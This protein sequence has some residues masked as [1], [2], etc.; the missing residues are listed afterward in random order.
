VRR[1]HVADLFLP[2]YLGLIAIWPSDWSG[3]RFLLPVLPVILFLAGEGTLRLLRMMAPRQAFV[4]GAAIVALFMAIEA[5]GLRAAAKDS[6]QCIAAYEAG[7]QYPCIGDFWREYFML[8]EMLPVFVPDSSV[9]IT[10]NPRMT[11][12]LGGVQSMIWPFSD[13]PNAFFAAADSVAARYLIYDGATLST[14]YVRPLLLEYPRAFCIM[15]AE[16][17]GTL[18]F[19]IRP[20]RDLSQM[21]PIASDSVAFSFCGEEYW[22]DAETMRRFSSQ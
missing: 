18:L 3:E 12:A 17:E 11:Y 5:P 8:S 15:R 21:A 19:G 20:E 14:V 2:L 10:R 22:R 6:Q 4:A 9:V 13:D 16:R 1:A 7:D